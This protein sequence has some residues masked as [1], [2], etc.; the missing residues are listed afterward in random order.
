MDTTVAV[1]LLLVALLVAWQIMNALGRSRRQ[2]RIDDYVFPSGLTAKVRQTYPQLSQQQ[3][4]LVIDNLREYF[5]MCNTAGR[6]MVAMPSQAVDVAWHEFILNTRNYHKF[7]LA[8]LGRFLHHTP[9][10]A[11]TSPTLAQKGIKT[12]WRIACT[13]ENISRSNP[14]K[15]PGLFAL[16]AQLDIADGFHYSLD[17]LAERN[18][19][20]KTDGDSQRTTYCASHIG[21]G[22]GCAGD[23]GSDGGCGGGCGG[24]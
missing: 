10:E 14:T 21:C 3:A 4:Q 1:V 2:R 18:Q 11:M 16:D 19:H 5:H 17:C 12:A 15:L 20:G 24:D 8:A 7:C 22:S 9:A 23:S 6:R 13:R